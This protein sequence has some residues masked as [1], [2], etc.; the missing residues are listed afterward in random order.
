M[1]KKKKDKRR[2]ALM[3]IGHDYRGQERNGHVPQG[4]YKAPDG[5]SGYWGD[6]E[7]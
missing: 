2:V 4:D 5:I 7:Q 3:P 6:T 1:K